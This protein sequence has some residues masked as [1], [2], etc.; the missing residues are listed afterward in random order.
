MQKNPYI[1]MGYSVVFQYKSMW[2][3]VK[4]RV[5]ICRAYLPCPYVIHHIFLICGMRLFSCPN[6][7]REKLRS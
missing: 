2:Y 5:S 1:F 6:C 3:S 7:V 4:I